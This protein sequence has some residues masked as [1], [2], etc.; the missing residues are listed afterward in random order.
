MMNLIQKFLSKDRSNK[1][2][3]RK[4]FS[5][6]FYS[7]PEH[8]WIVESCNR[9]HFDK[10]FS[11]LPSGVLE[12]MMTKYPVVFIP[13]YAMKESNYSGM[14]LANTVV[15]FPEF[16]R[17]LISEKKSAVA[18]LAHELAFILLELEG[19][20]VGDS[21]MAEVEADKFVSDLGLT[22]ELEELLLMLDETIEK[23]VR[24][25][26]LTINHFKDN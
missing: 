19:G 16:Q 25:T 20:P 22:F 6:Y 21:I 5:V 13:S 23:R 10:L 9:A 4:K 18:Y 26:Y 24:L 11:H 8:Q 2:H 17:L 12:A 7:L 1:S 15:V 3:I 14:A